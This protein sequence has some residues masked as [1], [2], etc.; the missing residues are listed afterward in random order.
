V[1]LIVGVIGIDG[2]GKGSNI[3]ACIRLLYPKYSSLVLGW[4]AVSYINKGRVYSL[5]DKSTRRHE[6]VVPDPLY[7]SPSVSE[8]LL[9]SWHRLRKRSLIKSLQPFYCFEDR[10]LVVDPLI[11]AVSYLGVLRGLS[12][13]TR[14]RCMRLV[15]GGRLS[16]CYVYLDV[17]PETALK[18]IKKRHQLEGKKLS[19]HENLADLRL[20]Q[21][22][23]EKVLDYLH[24]QHV[25]VIRIN[26]EDK[27][28]VSCSR[29]IV[30]ALHALGTGDEK[31]QIQ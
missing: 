25:P 14:I 23:Y 4:K 27:S 5:L 7:Q 2:S 9:I 18:R 12:I 30:A 28:V 19:K 15:T 31:H 10:D 22:Q 17:K 3:N 24:A 13:S 26:T 8:R 21:D 1:T 6:I 11:L 16:D 29:E 20:L